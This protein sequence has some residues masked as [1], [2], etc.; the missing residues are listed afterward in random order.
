MIYSRRGKFYDALWSLYKT[1]HVCV[2]ACVRMSDERKRR[3]YRKDWKK[4]SSLRLALCSLV[5][6]LRPLPLSAGSASGGTSDFGDW[7]TF[8]AGQPAAPS[9]QPLGGAGTDLFGNIQPPPAQVSS[10]PSADL[11]DLIGSSQATLSASQ[12]L[13]FSLCSTQAISGGGGLP[14]SRS[15]VLSDAQPLLV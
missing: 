9:S 14:M 15:Q 4:P 1:W 5:S 8:P 12:S 11:F 2:R 13:N 10:P 7:N 3:L 6:A